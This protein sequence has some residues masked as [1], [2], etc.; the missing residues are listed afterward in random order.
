[1]KHNYDNNENNFS[2]NNI[3]NYKKEFEYEIIQVL[4][5]IKDLIIEYYKFCIDNIKIKN[6]NNF[7]F[8]IIR[9]L[10]TII[11]VFNISLFY[12]K[13]LELTYFQSQKAMYLYLE[14]ICQINDDEKIFLQLNSRDAMVYVY[15]KTIYEINFDYK[16]NNENINEFT[17]IKL[18]II[19]SY[20]NIYKLLLYKLINN[21]FYNHIDFDNIIQ[22]IISINSINNKSNI[23]ILEKYIEYIYCQ[24]ININ[25]FFNFNTSL[26]KKII[27]NNEIN[28]TYILEEFYTL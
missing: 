11:N 7:K 23:S 1:M 26:F 12:T 21:D 8:I 4:D 9:G 16:K 27:S 22:L 15:K 2:Y 28:Y 14:F 24:I 19:N 13:N 20:I 18:N 5:K 25:D 10:D 17:Q 6:L 3:D